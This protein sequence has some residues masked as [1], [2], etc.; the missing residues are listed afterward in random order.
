MIRLTATLA[1]GLLASTLAHAASSVTVSAGHFLAQASGD[2]HWVPSTNPFTGDTTRLFVQGAD[3]VGWYDAGGGIQRPLLQGGPYVPTEARADHAFADLELNRPGGP[4][5]A[6]S[7][8]TPEGLGVTIGT[9]TTGGSADASASWF[10]RFS[11][12]AGASVTLSWDA[13]IQGSN[14]GGADFPSFQQDILPSNTAIGRIIALV[15]GQGLTDI[16]SGES[17]HDHNTG[18]SFSQNL[19]RELVIHNTS[20]QARV[21]DFQL[22]V[23]ANTRDIVTEVPEP[24]GFA[25]AALGLGLLWVARRKI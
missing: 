20:D 16:L 18:F 25:L 11:L 10:T 15:N 22:S 3:Q 14:G 9:P 2:F 17:F 8:S 7:D 6:L 4:S 23:S 13:L 12:G 19:R 24:N 1:A 21:Y 5:Q